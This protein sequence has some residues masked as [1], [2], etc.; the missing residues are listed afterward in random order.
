MYY[1][2]PQSVVF[3][4][5]YSTTIDIITQSVAFLLQSVVFPTNC[6]IILQNIVVYHKIVFYLKM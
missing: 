1:I 4:L 6:S 5:E 2:L 3:P